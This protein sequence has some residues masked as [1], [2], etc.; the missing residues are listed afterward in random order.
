M[1]PVLYEQGQGCEE[2]ARPQLLLDSNNILRKV[3]KLK[4]TREPAIVPPRKLISLGMSIAINQISATSTSS[5]MHVM[6]NH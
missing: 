3:V 1:R 5:V 2:D 4:Y 6:A